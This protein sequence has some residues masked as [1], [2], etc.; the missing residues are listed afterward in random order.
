MSSVV[1]CMANALDRHDDIVEVLQFLEE[2]VVAVRQKAQRHG[3]GDG[4]VGRHL[5]VQRSEERRAVGGSN[6]KRWSAVAHCEILHE[7]IDVRTLE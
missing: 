3:L 4:L 1:G 5:A 6:Q 7:S 2:I